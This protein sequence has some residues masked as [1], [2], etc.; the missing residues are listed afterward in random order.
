MIEEK[1]R[2][3][4]LA[5]L[6]AVIEYLKSYD[7]LVKRNPEVEKK[8]LAKNS[9]PDSTSR[10]NPIP[11]MYRVLDKDRNTIITPKE[12]SIAIDDYLAKRSSYS[13][14]EFFDLIDLHYRLLQQESLIFF[15]TCEFQ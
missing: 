6:P 15:Q 4:S 2:K 14:S 11:Q 3:D 7:K 1:F 9:N 10:I 8:W 13:V 12:I 5:A